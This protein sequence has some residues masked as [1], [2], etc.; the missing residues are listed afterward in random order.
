MDM[1][2]KGAMMRRV[3]QMV[4]LSV[5]VIGVLFFLFRQASMTPPCEKIIEFTYSRTQPCN[6]EYYN[7][8]FSVGPLM[9]LIQSWK[10]DQS[11]SRCDFRTS[12]KAWVKSHSKNRADS[13]TDEEI[14]EL[15]RKVEIV[16]SPK[17]KFGHPILCV[18]KFSCDNSNNLGMLTAAYKECM[19]AYVERENIISAEKATMR[20]IVAFQRQE[21]EVQKLKSKLSSIGLSANEVEQLKRMIA[22]AERIALNSKTEWRAAIKAYREKWDASLVFLHEAD[23][24]KCRNATDGKE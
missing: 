23:A 13:L 1:V 19:L 8:G 10:R 2:K 14:D 21:R 4:V 6:F 15:C 17:N 22:D 7:Y 5:V 16:Q 11:S 24:S 12:L 9:D 18:M 3:F 20:E